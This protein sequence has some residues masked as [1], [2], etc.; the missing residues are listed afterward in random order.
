[1]KQSQTAPLFLRIKNRELKEKL[2]KLAKKNRRSTQAE[3]EVLLEQAV[4]RSAV[5]AADTG[6]EP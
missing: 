1:M 5:P 4:E 3:A 2:G 6:E